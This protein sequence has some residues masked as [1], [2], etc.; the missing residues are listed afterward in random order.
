MSQL[1]EKKPMRFPYFFLLLN[2][3]VMIGVYFVLTQTMERALSSAIIQATQAG[4]SDITRVFINEV[5]PE[6]EV[7]LALTSIPSQIKQS[8]NSKELERVDNRVRS[9]MFGT[10]VLKAKIFNIEGITIYSSEAS[11]VGKNKYD[12]KGFSDAVKGLPASQVTHRGQFSSLDGDVFDRDLV[13]SYIPIRN[14]QDDIIGVAELYADRSS[15]VEHSKELVAELKSELIPALMVILLLVAVIVWRFT[16]YV[17]Q[18]KIEF[19]QQ[20]DSDY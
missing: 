16:S 11:Q 20:D 4:N 18:L 7:D 12:N 8:L 19:L 2:L 3:L 10:D 9:F 6:L 1:A 5:Y 17:T 14:K 13:S 15:E